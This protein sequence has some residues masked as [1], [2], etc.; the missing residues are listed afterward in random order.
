MSVDKSDPRLTAYAFD[1]LSSSEKAELEAELAND[2][3]AAVELD[4]IQQTLALLETE[5][6]RSAPSKLEHPRRQEIE[7]LAREPR[8]KGLRRLLWGTASASALAAGALLMLTT[9]RPAMETSKAREPMALAPSSA[10]VS[11][12]QTLELAAA[13][14]T[15]S[16]SPM[17]AAE[18]VKAGEWDDNANY[19]ELMRWLG[20]RPAPTAHDI[21][22]RDRRFIVVRD[23]QGLGVPNCRVL[24]EDM[25]QR[26]AELTTLANGRAILF[27]RAEGL[28]GQVFTATTSCGGGASRR[29]ALAD[30]SQAVELRLEGPRSLPSRN[31]D[32]VFVLD[33]TGSMNEEIDAVKATVAKVA[34]GLRDANVGIRLGLVD[35]KDRGD[36]Y[37]TRMLPLSGDLRGFSRQVSGLQAI[38]GGDTPES[39]NEA[40]HVAINQMS[41]DSGAFAK[42][43]FL[44]GD[45]P[46]HLD[47]PQD[48]DYVLEAREAAHRGIQVFTVAASGMDTVGQVVWRQ[49]AAYT[50]ATNLFVLRGGAGPQSTGA[51]DP[52]SSCG[53]SQTAYTSGNLDALVLA[54]INGAIKSLDRD[55]M[56]IPGLLTDENAKPCGERIFNQ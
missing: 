35:Y 55:P 56:R 49:V 12:P 19:R 46:P 27:P 17:V 39:A 38:G 45:A 16:P 34:N 54:K 4:E 18:S 48:Y 10:W 30:P 14:P 29:F 15:A 31:I 8:R 28:A 43:A 13:S 1:E 36:A 2:E 5:L 33:T 24:I 40:L 25:A 11:P 44:I 3:D 47:Y 21:D 9:A 22:L 53:G 23:V 52:K 50:G 7:Q 37:V 42:L 51:G 32:V 20:T 41:W 26:Q 6:T